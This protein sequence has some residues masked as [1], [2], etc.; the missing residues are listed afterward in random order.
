[1]VD[2]N[3]PKIACDI[4]INGINSKWHHGKSAICLSDSYEYHNQHF[5]ANLI[6]IVLFGYPN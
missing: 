3:L 2:D 5:H 4:H 1:M 6:R